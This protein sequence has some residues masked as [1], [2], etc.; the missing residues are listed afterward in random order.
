MLEGC[1]IVGM[2][3]WLLRILS[4]SVIQ[5]QR[6]PVILQ[7]VW[8]A[9]LRLFRWEWDF[10][11]LYRKSPSWFRS[12]RI[13]I[14]HRISCMMNLLLEDFRSGFDILVGFEWDTSWLAVRIRSIRYPD[15]S[16][17]IPFPEW[18][19][20]EPG[21]FWKNLVKTIVLCVRVLTSMKFS[22][23]DVSVT[24]FWFFLQLCVLSFLFYRIFG[25]WLVPLAP[26]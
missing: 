9:A 25:G 14:C 23:E 4:L 8:F 16:F 10:C 19:V 13:R 5:R 17:V 1:R 18:R 21:K 22:T 24:S 12:C 7:L 26:R 20:T 15:L 3:R 6:L 11:T 2:F